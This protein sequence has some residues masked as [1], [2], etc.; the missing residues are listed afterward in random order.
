VPDGDLF[1]AISGGKVSVVTD[2]IERFTQGGIRLKSGGEIEAD[3]V[4][5]ATGLV[6]K[7]MGGIALDVDGEA[8]TVADRFVYKGM[9][10]DGVPNFAL[11]FG[12]INASWTL[13]CDLTALYV[14]RLLNFMDRRGYAAC[15]PRL[16][17]P[18]PE[19]RPIL[20][21]SSGYVRRAEGLLPVQGEKAPWRIHQNYFRDLVVLRFETLTDP[22][23]EF[24][25]LPPNPS[26]RGKPGSQDRDA[27]APVAS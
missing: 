3:V 1:E 25:R 18:A 2:E 22:A 13:K 24:R 14:C 20:D 17:D 27:P 4:V 16:P 7:L 23:M 19:R 9:M 26:P 21:F 11:S 6:M 8:V 5:A 10:L 12:Y 15:T